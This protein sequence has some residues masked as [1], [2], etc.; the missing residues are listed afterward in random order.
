[1]GNLYRFVEP[2]VLLLLKEKASSYGYDL[3]NEAGKHALTDAELERAV[4]YRTLRTLETNGHVVSNWDTEGPGP[5]RRIYR[6]TPTGEEHLQEWAA[7][8][9]HVGKAMGRFV[10]RVETLNGGSG[11]HDSFKR[12]GGSTVSPPREKS[13]TRR[14]RKPV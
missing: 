6:L 11:K 1:M 7:V 9:Q 5:A 12:N 10:R 3:W 4:F 8:L 2:V 14:D 13:E